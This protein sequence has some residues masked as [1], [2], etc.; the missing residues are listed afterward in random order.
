MSPDYSKAV[1]VIAIII[2]LFCLFGAAI[3]FL[4]EILAIYLA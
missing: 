3:V 1:F 4:T 2:V